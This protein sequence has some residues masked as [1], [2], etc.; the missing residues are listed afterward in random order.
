[1]NLKIIKIW[2]KLIMNLKFYRKKKIFTFIS[3]IIFILGGK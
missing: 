1:M 3:G 2:A